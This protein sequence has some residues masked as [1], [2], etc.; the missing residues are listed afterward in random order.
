MKTES[1]A[2][3]TGVTHTMAEKSTSGM[4]FSANIPN[5]VALR[6]KLDR[7]I[8]NRGRRE[9]MRRGS[10]QAMKTPSRSAV[11]NGPTGVAKRAAQSKQE[12]GYRA[13]CAGD[14]V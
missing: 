3:R 8:C 11:L 1:A 14:H 5:K 13:E 12:S 2:T 10:R 4:I 6:R 9:T 7:S